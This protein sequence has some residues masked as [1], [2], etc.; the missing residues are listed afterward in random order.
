M[1]AETVAPTLA[2]APAEL[3]RQL[4]IRVP[5][6]LHRRIRHVLADAGPETSVSEVVVALIERGLGT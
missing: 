3:T 2:H 6:A 1:H 5:D 4:R